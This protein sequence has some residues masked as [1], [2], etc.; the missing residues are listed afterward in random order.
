[1]PTDPLLLRAQGLKDELV[2]LRRDLHRHP[3][4]S[5]QEERTAE[6]GRA[7]LAALGMEALPKVAGT[8]GVL[9]TLDSGKPGRT[10]I[11]RADM[12]A[13]P[14]TEAT[15]TD[16]ASHNKGVMHACGHDAHVACA[17][18]AAKLLAENKA[19]FKGR[20][21]VVLQPAEE[22]PPGG[23]VALIEKGGILN[24]VDAA[25]ALHVHPGIPVGQLGFRPGQMLAHS[26][27]FE[28][29][30]KGVGAHAARP[31][32]SVDAI[33]VAVQVYQALQYLV[34][35]END[36]LHPFVIT[37][38]AIHGGTAMNVITDTVVLRGTTRCLDDH[39]AR[40]LP[41]KMERVIAGV[42]SATRAQYAFEFTR[43]YPA[44]VNDPAFTQRAAGS[45]AAMLGEGAVHMIPNAEMGG[46]DFAYFSQKVPATMFR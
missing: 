2:L 32:L 21:K 31:Q 36:P 41:E 24:G 45:V 9:G 34:S 26:D 35:R 39:A 12:D 29:T 5:Y 13:L 10:I 1:M 8:H 42:C 18:G 46:E 22:S 33:A 37:V 16:Y 43:G 19:N 14:I 27:R 20:V 17:L 25:I 7:Y 6:K 40:H 38:G 15:A 44:L 3:E 28:L 30:I 4:L 23:A 11:I